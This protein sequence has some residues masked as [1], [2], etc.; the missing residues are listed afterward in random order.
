MKSFLHWLLLTLSLLVALPF[1]ILYRVLGLFFGIKRIFPGCSQFL[2][3][4]PGRAGQILRR[5]FYLMALKRCSSRCT[6]DFGT[7][8][9][10]MDVV[11]G[12]HV[13][14]GAHCIISTCVIEDD[15]I[16]GSG[17]HVANKEMHQFDSLDKPIRLQGGKRRQIRIGR[18]CWIGNKAIVMADVGDHCVIGAGSVV[19][20]PV[21]DR[22]V[23]VG[24]PARV[25]RKRRKTSQGNTKT[26]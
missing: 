13:Y 24:N 25:I 17:V 7:F 18:D 15:V 22:S 3:L 8:F 4:F 5:G 26:Q 12:K 16:I 21:E 9:P 11:L 14:I 23:A 6:I 10:C 20:K 19:T 2:S 1:Y